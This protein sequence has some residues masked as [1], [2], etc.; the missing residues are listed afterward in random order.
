MI[1]NDNDRSLY[2]RLRISHER[3]FYCNLEDTRLYDLSPRDFPT[4]LSLIEEL[5]PENARVFLD[6]VQEVEGWQQILRD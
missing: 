3:L 5:A 1:A 2:V 4:F 6:E